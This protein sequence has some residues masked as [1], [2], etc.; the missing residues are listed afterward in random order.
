MSTASPPAARSNPCPLAS[1]PQHRRNREH[2]SGFYALC[3][4][5]L[6]ERFAGTLLGS[7]LLLYLSERLWMAL[8]A[9]TRIGSALNAAVYLS[10]VFGGVVAYR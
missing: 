8:S 10:S 5:E 3:A 9:S 7:L 1:E 2:P 4:V 6:F